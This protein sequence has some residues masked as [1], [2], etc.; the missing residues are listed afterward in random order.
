MKKRRILFP[1]LFL[2]LGCTFLLL[3]CSAQK[4]R[5]QAA[6]EPLP[7]VQEPSQIQKTPLPIEDS[8]Q[9]KL[10]T[11]CH[12]QAECGLFCQSNRGR[13]ENYCYEHQDNQLC[14]LLFP[15]EINPAE[16]TESSSCTGTKILFEHAPVNL[17][18]TAVFLPLGL[19]TGNHV[20]PI[21][22]HYFQNFENEQADIEV[23]SPGDGAVV[24]IGHMPGA[25][26]GEDYRVVIQHTCTIS[27]IYIHI[28]LLAEKFAA[29]LPENYAA[30]QIPVKAGE[31]IGYY[32]TNVDYN[33]VDEEFVL[34]GYVIPE[35]YHA[36]PWKIHVP[37]TYDYFNEP[38]RSALRA[39]S[40]RT[41]E[42][43]SG[44]IDYDIDG[45]LVG[46]WFEEGSNGY[47]G[48]GVRQDYWTT[49]LAFAYDFLDP[50][51][52]IVSLGDFNGQPK[53]F[54]VEG[55]TPNPAIISTASGLVKYELM[56]GGSYQTETGQDW[57]RRS[58]AK[59]VK[60]V[61]GTQLAGVVLVQMLDN[62][63]IKFEAIPGKT[64][65]PVTGF[66]EKARIYE[67]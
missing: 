56:E 60:A 42:P 36:E 31:L 5:E 7:V 53:Q 29:A 52:I 19:M 30:V 8:V 10:G 59:I 23:Y 26:T 20:T 6:A 35:H 49:H 14:Q 27:S 50:S 41:I 45:R 11:L 2:V 38:V 66:T 18:K 54:A 17:E 1:A 4:Q 58:P 13:C 67:R 43:L 34:S 55:N 65:S 21:D 51:L 12:G 24:E 47:V 37:N 28:Q 33:L 44:K 16:E 63:K 62:R 9:S 15:F 3:A 39:K 61:G 48:G 22:H 40:V 32:S 46:N 64:A 57:D 25:P